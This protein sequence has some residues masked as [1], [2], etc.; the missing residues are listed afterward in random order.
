MADSL[1]ELADKIDN[2]CFVEEAKA[3]HPN[4]LLALE[5]PKSVGCI[6][7][8]EGAL[9]YGYRVGANIQ[10]DETA[11]WLFVPVEDDDE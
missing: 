6:S 4:C 3:V 8:F 11:V 5:R 7:T 9:D 2:H 1:E 10:L